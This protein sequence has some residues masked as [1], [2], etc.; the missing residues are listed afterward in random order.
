MFGFDGE[1]LCFTCVAKDATLASF[2]GKGVTPAPEARVAGDGCTR[3]EP[4]IDPAVT[5]SMGDKRLVYIVGRNNNNNNNGVQKTDGCLDVQTECLDSPRR[6]RKKKTSS[7]SSLCS[8]AS[9]STAPC[10]R[11]CSPGTQTARCTCTRRQRR[12]RARRPSPEGLDR[13]DQV[14]YAE[15]P[16]FSDYGSDNGQPGAGGAYGHDHRCTEESVEVKEAR[17]AREA[18]AARQRAR[19]ELAQEPRASRN[20]NHAPEALFSEALHRV[21]NAGTALKLSII[22]VELKDV[23]AALRK[24]VAEVASTSARRPPH[25]N[26]TPLW[27]PGAWMQS[28]ERHAVQLEL[29]SMLQHDTDELRLM[30]E[31]RELLAES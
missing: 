29:E 24:L 10:P 15:E 7:A 17:E 5:P 23:A 12:L 30:D 18:R 3:E 28:V 27:H 22:S 31:V 2:P 1:D 19:A 9:E 26:H 25:E 8:P 20:G 21:S 14:I 11:H 4:S 13:Y 6:S 16:L